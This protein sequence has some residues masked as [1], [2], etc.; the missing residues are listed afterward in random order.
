M[1]KYKNVIILLQINENV[2]I[3]SLLQ[4]TKRHEFLTFNIDIK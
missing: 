4:F 1:I 2:I 3:I